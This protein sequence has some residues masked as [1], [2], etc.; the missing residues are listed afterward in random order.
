LDEALEAHADPHVAAE[1]AGLR[2]VKE[3]EPGLLRKRWGRGFTYLL[4]DGEHLDNDDLR[5]RIDALAIPP[6]WTDV[7]ICTDLNGHILAT[8]RD[9]EGRKQYRYHPDW[10]QIRS[11]AKFNRLIPFGEALSQIRARCEADL[12][13][14]V[15]RILT[16]LDLPVVS[17]VRLRLA[18]TRV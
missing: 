13:G 2:Y 15:T 6:A 16:V 14:T 4:P 1:R 8:G 12:D 9:E 7:W 5:D 3:D 17:E 18:K 11:E 10:Q